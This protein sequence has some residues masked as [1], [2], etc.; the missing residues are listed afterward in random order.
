MSGKI[1]E[2]YM[3][4]KDRL[5]PLLKYPGGKDNELKYILP[6]LPKKADRFFEPFLGGGAVYFAVEANKMLVNDYSDELIN[7][8]ERV[9]EADKVFHNHLADII[10]NWTLLGS[11]PKKHDKEIIEIY[12]EFSEDR[13]TEQALNDWVI[14]FFIRH[15]VELN[16]MLNNKLNTNINNFLHELNKN[17]L[18]KLKRMKKIELDRGKLPDNDVIDNYEASIKSG[19]YMHLRHLYNNISKYKFT[20]SFMAALYFFIRNYC[21]SSMFRYNKSGSFNVPYGGIGYNSKSL[22]KKLEYFKDG[23]L[24]K[25]LDKTKICNQDFEDFLRINNPTTNDFIFLDPPYDSEFSTYSQNSFTKADQKR[26]A[27]YLISDCKAKWM[28]VIKN[29]EFIYDL[30]DKPTIKISSFEKKYLV[31]FMNR[32]DKDVNHLLITN[33]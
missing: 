29:T 27:S 19:L 1:I 9:A 28:L 12:R 20:K 32:N 13:L 24:L 10:H 4:K 17:V 22:S 21:Y 3:I 31:S 5:S 8:Y 2:K 6:A 14:S 11:F 15:A 7:L 18:S 16:G 23:T 25:H 33:Y 30:Y 26:L